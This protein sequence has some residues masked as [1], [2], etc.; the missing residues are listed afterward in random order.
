M[1][2]WESCFV[3][4][5]RGAL[6]TFYFWSQVPQSPGLPCASVL[7]LGLVSIVVFLMLVDICLVL[8]LG[9]NNGT[10]LGRKKS[11][12]PEISIWN[13]K[14]AAFQVHLVPILANYVEKGV[15]YARSFSALTILTHTNFQISV[16]SAQSKCREVCDNVC[17]TVF[18]KNDNPFAHYRHNPSL[19]LKS[20]I[21]LF[22][23]RF[24]YTAF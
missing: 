11:S 24:I 14:L 15:P 5:Y 12:C 20:K 3:F 1:P 13:S 8:F 10:G 18:R 21:Y 2:V 9:Q 23:F 17:K 16:S 19:P 6:F 4:L 7:Y 22:F